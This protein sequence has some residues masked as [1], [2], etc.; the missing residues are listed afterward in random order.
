MADN[1]ITKQMKRHV[2]IVALRAD[3][4]NLKYGGFLNVTRSFVFKIRNQ[5]Q[6]NTENASQTAKR[7]KHSK[8]SDMIRKDDFIHYV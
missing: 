2:V 4:G 1:Q 3:H 7:K 5:L 6:N 8:R